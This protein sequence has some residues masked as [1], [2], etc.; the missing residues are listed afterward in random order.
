M[1]GLVESQSIFIYD[2][3][4]YLFNILSRY[5]VYGLGIGTFLES[6]GIPTAGLVLQLGSGALIISGNTTFLIALTISTIGLT[7]GSIA[8][9]YLGYFGIEVFHRFHPKKSKRS[10][11]KLKDFLVRHG[12]LAIFLAQLFGPA[13]T[14]ISIPAG[15]MRL[16]IKRFVIFTFL[17]GLLYSAIAISLSIYA[18]GLLRSNID[19]VLDV[20]SIPVMIGFTFGILL[21]IVLLRSILTKKRR[22]N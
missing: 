13:R 8:S 1:T 4:E 9:Y 14:W 10:R 21:T 15:V 18:T 20:V 11:S 19:E 6:I 3:G 17:G 2:L 7:L 22:T 12:D 16:D 5:G